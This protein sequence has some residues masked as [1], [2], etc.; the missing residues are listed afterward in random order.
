M[1]RRAERGGRARGGADLS[2]GMR[3]YKNQE[4]YAAAIQQMD[5]LARV[6]ERGGQGPAR[7]EAP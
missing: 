1:L 2:F 6:L 4:E 5:M 3:H 7:S